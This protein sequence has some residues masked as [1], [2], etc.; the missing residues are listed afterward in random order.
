MRLLPAYLVVLAVVIAF[1]D[2]SWAGSSS[3]GR[4]CCVAVADGFF[5]R[6]QDWQALAF[7]GLTLPQ[8]RTHA[9]A[10]TC[11]HRRSPHESTATSFHG[12]SPHEIEKPTS[13]PRS[14]A[15]QR[16]QYIARK[17]SR[18]SIQVPTLLVD[19]RIVLQRV[20]HTASI[21]N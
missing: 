3:C 15:S 18:D 2:H 17:R 13:H 12:R 9:S 19:A 21:Y 20:A 10:A 16:H 4:V 7:V 6:V 11:F 5:F 1:S 14:Q 8:Y